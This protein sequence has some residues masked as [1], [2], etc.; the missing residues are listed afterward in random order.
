MPALSTLKSN[1]T[2]AKNTLAREEGEANELLQQEWRENNEQQIVRFC[3]TIGKVILNLETKLARLEVANDRL[4]DAYDSGNDSEAATEFHTTLEEDSELMD[5]II[6]KISQLKTLKEEVERKRKEFETSETQNLERRLT[7]MQEQMSLLQSNRTHPPGELSSIWSPPLSSGTSKPPQIDIPPFAGDVLK[8]KEFWDMF[9]ASVH[10]ETRYA[11][12]DKFICLKSKLTGDALKAVAGYQ[13]S[14]ENYSVVVDVLKKRFGNKQ[15]VIDA[16]YHNLSHLPP[17]TNQVSSLRQCYDTIERNLRSL[18]AI[19]EDVSHRHFIAL[20]S[21][22]LPQKVLYQLYMLQEEGEEWTV[23]KLRHFLGK[24]ISAMEMAGAEFSQMFT[25]PGN[26]SRSTQ[27]EHT[28]KGY[29]N[30]R[31]SASELLAG[32]GKASVPRQ[33]KIKCI[34]CD[35]SHWSDECPNCST[36]QERREKLKGFCYVCLKKG[37]MSKNCTRNKIC[38]HCG[39]KNEHHRSLCPTLFAN[40]NPSSSLSSVEDVADNNPTDV[41]STNVLMQTATATVKNTVGNCSKSVRLLLD[42]GSQRTY[43][44]EKLAKEIK[45]KL[46]PSESFSIA[47]FGV[48]P[49]KQIQCKSSELQLVLKDGSLMPIKVTVIPNITGKLTRAPL[50][51]SDVEFLKESSMEDKLADTLVTNAESFQIDMVLGN[52]YYFDL[53]QPRKMDM[54]NGLFLFQSKLGWVCGGKVTTETEVVSESTLFV[55]TVGAAPINMQTAAHMLPAVDPCNASKPSIESFWELE[56]LGIME[57][58]LTSED[59]V[60]LDQFNTTVKFVDGRYMVTWPWKEKNGDLPENY[61][62]AFGRLKSTIQKLVK[63]PKLFQQYGDIIQEQLQRGI[64]EKVTETSEEGSQ[65]HYIPHHPVITPSKT[66]TKLRV[67]YDASA[68]TRKSNKSLNECLYR[69]PVMLPELT[70]LLLRFRLS[71]IA[72]ISDIEK[73]FLNVGLQAKDRDVTRFLWLKNTENSDTTNNLQVYR[74]CRIPFGVISSPFL[75]AAVVYHHLKQVGS[76]VAERIRR[77]IYVDNLITGAQTEM[78]AH[79]LYIEGKQVFSTASMNLREWASNSEELM[80]LIPT[81]DRAN[82]S[83]IKV[84]GISWNLKN[85]QL[86]IP[87]PSGNEKLCGASTKREILQAT[88]SIYDPM[89]YFAPTILEAKLFIQELWID[90]LQWDI[91]LSKEKLSKWNHICEDL[92]SISMH[93]IPR[94]LGIKSSNHHVTYSLVCFCDAS[95][96]AYAATVYLHQDSSGNC[97]ADL[98]FS[99]TRLAPHKSVTIPQLELLGVLIGTRALRFVQKELHLPI[100]S[101][102]LWTD[103]QCVIHWL[104]SRKPLPIFV[105]NRLKEIRSLKGVSIKY[106]PTEENLA[107]L[108]ARGKS[109]SELMNSIWWNGPQWLSQT[110]DQWPDPKISLVQELSSE[111]SGVK[112]LYEAK[113]AVG[114]S[115]EGKIPVDL[116][117]IKAERFS[118]LQRLLKV[119]AWIVRFINKLT[120][121]STSAT[122]GPLTAEEIAKAKLLWDT[123]IQQKRFADTI[124]MIK[125][126]EQFNLKDQLN[127]MLDQHGVIRCHGRYQNAQLSQGAKYPKLLP[128]KE[129]YTQLVIEDSHCNMLHAGVSQT[130]AEIR[131]NY[132][133]P[134]GRSEVRKVLKNCKVC[135][136]TEGGPF[137]MPK[138]PPWPKERVM[139]S[140][141][142]EYTGVD[143]FGPMY[144]KYYT[145]ESTRSEPPVTKKVWICLFT[146]FAVRAI[147]LELAEDMTAE[148]FL[149]CLRRFIARRGKPKQILSDNAK[150]FK[151]ASKVLDDIWKSVIISDKVDEFSTSK[152]IQWK[153]IVELAPWMGGLYERLVGRA[154]RKAIGN[155]CLTEKQLVTVLTEVE[156]VINSRPLVYVDDDINS[157][158]IITPS[159]FL[160]LNHQHFI[161][162]QKLIQIFK[163]HR[164]EILHI[165]F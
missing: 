84:L 108:A 47:T 2:R 60:A 114:E 160:S 24:H 115:P 103:S 95:A 107:D 121:K 38:A 138:M 151:T 124:R 41:A 82:I 64:I 141:P 29:L 147:H 92:E 65:K 133:I 127:L 164:Q 18:E 16:Y 116:S 155:Q 109:P 76:P 1:R 30:T 105:T 28:R 113:L 93:H 45:L 143:Y 75:L 55:S 3:L 78:E 5:N 106:I 43:I 42:S 129:Y 4:M 56:S 69:G 22:K 68:K 132:W 89:G 72:I 122:V 50:S 118:S 7:Q 44:T 17:A 62:L 119:T 161:L 25:Q 146:C 134:K 31:P 165:R 98:I 32:N 90:K 111:A 86:S 156:S 21:E 74:F 77:D 148:E 139:Q 145:A 135:Q 10:G 125:S 85:D 66:T 33:V 52:D 157:S 6:S 152:G 131:Q 88:A 54:G 9:E 59:D 120:K 101:K 48:N 57:S 39:K 137:K 51:L 163:F 112:V 140:V 144:V 126:G 40:K 27:N 159:S 91:E 58:P 149:L 8:W 79:K 49:S 123:Y 23:A 153:Y 154:L 87:G 36:L 96:K 136:R 117:D 158:I 100:S 26:T 130:L 35:Q 83:G 128:R 94:Y 99:K 97:K 67:V 19:G 34:F 20:I 81:Q 71:P 53:L 14:N 142:F 37:H 150:H 13:L 104:Q 15:L 61:Q 63:H 46:G 73:A 162:Q 102:V 12:I 110:K 80:K 11:N 70:G